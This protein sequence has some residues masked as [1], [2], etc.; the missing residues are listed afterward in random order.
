MNADLYPHIW[1]FRAWA[2]WWGA[3]LPVDLFN[4]DLEVLEPS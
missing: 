1:L 2:A 4:L 3:V